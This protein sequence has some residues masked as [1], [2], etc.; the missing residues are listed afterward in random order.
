MHFPRRLALTLPAL[1][2]AVARAQDAEQLPG[3]LRLATF[4]SGLEYPWGANF[5]PDGRLL[6]TERP[7]R[8]RLVTPDGHVSAPLAGLPEVE[9]VGQGG[10]LDVVVAPDFTRSSE[11]FFAAAV[12]TGEGALTRLYRARLGGSGLA[13]VR[14]VLDATPGQSRGRNHFGGR[15]AFSPDGAHLFLTTGDRNEKRDRAQRLD[16]LAGK[17]IRLTRNGEVPR[18]NPFFGRPGARGEIFSFGH[19]NPQGIAFNPATGSL[20]EVEFGPLGG[21]EVNLIRPGQNYGWPEV[22]YGREYSGRPINNGRTSAPG[23]VEPQRHWEPAISPS[24]MCFWR[25][26]L[27]L[28]CL[29]PPGLLRIAMEGDRLGGEERLWQRRARC[30]HVVPAPDGSLLVLTD[31]SRGRILR[32]A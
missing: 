7:G 22:T 23:F 5:L 4:A 12:S 13:E 6:V 24:G 31:E 29:N 8:M 20:F 17:V 10:L 25:G 3:G 2:P 27:W 14:P 16:D 28:A 26:A 32:I 11:I 1:L 21:D 19:R 15:L 18:D 9:A 30:R